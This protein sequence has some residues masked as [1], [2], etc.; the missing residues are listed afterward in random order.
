MDLRQTTRELI[1]RSLGW[2]WEQKSASMTDWLVYHTAIQKSGITQNS[3]MI[4]DGLE[5]GHILATISQLKPIAR[6]WIEYCYGPEN[7]EF[8]RS[9]LGTYL[10]W[11]MGFSPDG[12]SYARRLSLCKT[13][14]DDYRLRI[15]HDGKTLPLQVYAHAMD[16]K[17]TFDGKYPH[18]ARDWK[19]YV[20]KGVDLLQN[21][22]SDSIGYVSMTIRYLRG[23]NEDFKPEYRVMVT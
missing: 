10:F 13:I 1:I 2:A 7:N 22:D 6:S 8:D 21:I 3:H 16:I 17:P 4:V 5:V 15:A 12:K 9:Q 23:Q 19:P 18:W 14:S 11:K 20:D